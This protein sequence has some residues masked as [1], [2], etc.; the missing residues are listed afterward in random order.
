MSPDY[1]IDALLPAT[2]SQIAFAEPVPSSQNA[3]YEGANPAAIA[4]GE[5]TQEL[6]I[7]TDAVLRSGQTDFDTGTGWWLGNPNKTPKFSIGKSTGAKMTWDG[8]ILSI[9][10]RLNAINSAI[11][12]DFETAARFTSATTGSGAV[13][14]G[15]AGVQLS[16]GTT[17]PSRCSVRW[18][19]TFTNI[20]KG[21][22]IFSATINVVDQGSGAIFVGL[23]NMS[24]GYSG[25]TV[26]AGFLINGGNL[27][28]TV[29]DGTQTTTSLVA[30][31]NGDIIN[32]ALKMNA[33]SSVDFY[34][35]K[36]FDNDGATYNTDFSAPT[37]ISSNI[38]TTAVAVATFLSDNQSTTVDVT[39]QVSG[40]MYSV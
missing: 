2:P 33:S 22:P 10:G 40:A 36:F 5:I 19:P 23:G 12:T 3:F 11:A 24:G 29:S 28:A 16:T 8:S 26:H 17:N 31:T 9:I 14:F 35:R 18:Q 1:T 32:L 37:R 21:S 7:G 6:V 25:A 4:S 39:A 27:I 38:P 34:Y 20:F 30:V 13:T 15:V